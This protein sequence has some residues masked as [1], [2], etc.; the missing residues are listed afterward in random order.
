MT[1]FDPAAVETG[2]RTDVGRQRATN[3]DAFACGVTPSGARLLVVADGMGGHAGGATASRLAIETVERVIGSS[4][5]PPDAMLR[6]ALEE[7]NRCIYERSRQ[8]PS[9]AG[10][11]TTGVALLIVA[12]G[13]SCV[14]NVGDSRA[15]RLRDGELEQLTLDHSLVAELQRRG[16]LSE[17]QARV[18]PRRNEVLRSLGVDP[19]VEVDVFA[20]DVKPGDQYLLCSDGLSGVVDDPEIASVMRAD[21]PEVAA[22]RLVDAANARG[23]PDNITVVIARA[24]GPESSTPEA[25]GGSASAC[26]GPVGRLA[27]FLLATGLFAGTLLWR[28]L[29]E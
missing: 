19:S 26:R 23:G 24:P 22:R 4:T 20:V 5:E 1:T 28:L 14:A 13:S 25:G 8:D 21:P 10:M 3:Q 16:M 6:H 29:R 18:H 27:F 2:S 17:A 15:Y 12:D 9:V 11:G 7:A